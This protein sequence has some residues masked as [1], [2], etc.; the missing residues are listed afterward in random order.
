ME[1]GDLPRKTL[2]RPD[3]VA[4]FLS[5]SL[6]TIHRWYHSGLFEGAKVKG[7]LRIYRDSILKLVGEKDS[8]PPQ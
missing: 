2:L 6:K 5:V 7:S 1:F 8:L 3:E 4:L